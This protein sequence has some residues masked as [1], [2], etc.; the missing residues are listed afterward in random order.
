MVLSMRVSVEI[1][2]STLNDLRRLTGEEK[3]SPAIRRAVTE[4]VRRQRVREFGRLLREG[5]FDYPLTND[6]IESED[7]GPDEK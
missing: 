4:F 2:E 1:D 3:M 5:A 7:S 6:E